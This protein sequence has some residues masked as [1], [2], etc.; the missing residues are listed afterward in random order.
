VC[1]SNHNRK[2]RNPSRGRKSL[3]STKF[4]GQGGERGGM[5][6][7]E[8]VPLKKIEGGALEVTRIS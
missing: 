4:R 5:S 2:V 6:L 7:P 1:P 3:E 8:G